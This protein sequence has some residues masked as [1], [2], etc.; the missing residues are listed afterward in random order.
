[1]DLKK[2]FASGMFLFWEGRAGEAESKRGTIIKPNF[3]EHINFRMHLPCNATQCSS[4][5]QIK[6]IF[7]SILVQND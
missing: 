1:M 7:F 5:P 6:G 4:F 3:I 2:I